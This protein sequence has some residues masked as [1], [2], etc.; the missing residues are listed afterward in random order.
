M[1][2]R[3]GIFLLG[4]LLEAFV[5]K[6]TCSVM[7][8]T[9]T[10]CLE[11]KW[12]K[13]TAFYEPGLELKS[14]PL[15]LTIIHQLTFAPTLLLCKCLCHISCPGWAREWHPARMTKAL[16]QLKVGSDPLTKKHVMPVFAAHYCILEQ[17]MDMTPKRLVHC[18][19][20]V[21]SKMKLE[22]FYIKKWIVRHQ[23]WI[24][25][26]ACYCLFSQ[27]LVYLIPLGDRVSLSD[28]VFALHW[29]AFC[30]D[31]KPCILFW[32]NS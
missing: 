18:T 26:T 13:A 10:D 31:H 22:L 27:K 17:S 6:L 2:W 32:V 12:Q 14:A 21:T 30:S 3:A 8:C 25:V 4:F 7:S 16:T 29:V 5:W 24:D 1:G 19:R 28:R 20:K 11:S 23:Q 15:P 9:L